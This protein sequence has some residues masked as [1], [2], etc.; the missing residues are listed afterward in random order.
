MT[1]VVDGDTIR[2][3][4]DGI[5]YRLRYIGIDTPET[6]DPRRGVE[7]YGPEATLRNEQLVAGQTVGLEKDI[8]D[9]DEN[10]RL[11]R[12]VWLGGEMVNETLVREGFAEAVAYPPDTKH[13]GLLN[14]LEVEARSEQV[15][16]WSPACVETATPFRP[17][18]S[19]G[20]GQCEYSGTNEAMIKGNINS[21][22]ERVYHVP[23]QEN[24]AVTQINEAKGEQWFCTEAEAMAAGWRK[25]MR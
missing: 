8:S 6:M 7:C 9:V 23:G 15:G 18:V 22:G 10:G 16:L 3:E 17:L 5:E 4:I 2:V 13:Q 19:V 24:Y 12:Y 21:E 14:E 1:E 11:L 25:A 20:A